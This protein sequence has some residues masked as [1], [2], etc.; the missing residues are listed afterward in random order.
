[1]PPASTSQ[2]TVGTSGIVSSWQAR[3]DLPP[4]F[5]K[6]R[7]PSAR[8]ALIEENVSMPRRPPPAHRRG[9]A[10]QWRSRGARRDP[11]P[12]GLAGGAGKSILPLF[13]LHHRFHERI[14]ISL[15]QKRLH[16]PH[17]R[18]VIHSPHGAPQILKF[19]V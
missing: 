15:D 14:Q 17:G 2:P 19:Q 6:T 8:Y 1:M 5:A 3:S 13:L 4:F 10:V 12:R 7:S 16:C 11:C 18:E 9:R